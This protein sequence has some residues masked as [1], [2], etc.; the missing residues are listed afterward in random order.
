MFWSVLLILGLLLGVFGMFILNMFKGYVKF[1]E[2][3]NI[4]D[5]MKILHSG[6]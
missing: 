3:R 5:L 1:R 2:I 4:E 6:L